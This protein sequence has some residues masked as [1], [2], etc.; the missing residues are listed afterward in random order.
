MRAVA[1]NI[2]ANTNE[3]GFRGPVCPDGRFEYIPIPESEPTKERVPTYG[4]LAPHLETTIPERLTETP[5]HLDPE[6]SEYPHC[7]RYTYGD[8]H[9]VKAGPLSE[10]SAGDLLLFYATLTV[11]DGADWLPPEWGAFV[12]GEFVLASDP[13]TPDSEWDLPADERQYFENN[14]HTK[15]DPPDARVLL[16]GDP[17]RSRLYDRAVPLSTPTGG[18]D[19]NDIVTHLSADSGRGPWW[20]RPLRFDDAATTRLRDRIDD[21]A[22]RDINE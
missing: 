19:A 7:S 15:R 17:D 12:I 16:R 13:L 1:I 22:P 14:A 20:R 18:T 3:P 11:E 9:G 10:L 2:G 5:V 6:F 21:T 4:D 8:E